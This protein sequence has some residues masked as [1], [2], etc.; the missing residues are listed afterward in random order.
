MFL[1]GFRKVEVFIILFSTVSP[2]L[3]IVFLFFSGIKTCSGLPTSV[4]GAFNVANVEDERVKRVVAGF[5]FEV[6]V[7]V[8]LTRLGAIV[9]KKL[10]VLMATL[11]DA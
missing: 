9:R 10:F 2:P 8:L 4:S 6:D 1:N 5:G 3:N 11:A 7:T